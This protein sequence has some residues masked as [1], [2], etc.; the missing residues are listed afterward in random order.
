M[1]DQQIIELFFERNETAIAELERKYQPYCYT[2]AWNIL[3]NREDSEECVNDTWFSVWSYI[4]PKKPTV[5]S[6][7]IGKIT[8]GLA[9]DSLRSKGAGKRAD[10]HMVSIDQETEQ[11]DRL[12]APSMEDVLAEREL[13]RAM[14]RFLKNLPEADRDIFLRRYWYL[15]TTEEIARRHGKTEG[16]VKMN[17]YRSRKKLYRILEKETAGRSKLYE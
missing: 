16:A 7:F 4:P 10:L 15:D 3:K 9:I 11:I 1:N 17:L 13:V 2:I 6:A 5:L 8:R 12:V 14:N